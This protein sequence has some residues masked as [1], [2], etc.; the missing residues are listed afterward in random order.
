M[1]NKADLNQDGR[2][3]FNE[4]VIMRKKQRLSGGGSKGGS[5]GRHGSRHATPKRS[6]KEHGGHTSSGHTPKGGASH[7]GASHASKRH[8]AAGKREKGSKH[9]K[10]K[11]SASSASSSG[12]GGGI[13]GEAEIG[14]W[15][16]AHDRVLQAQEVEAIEERRQYVEAMASKHSMTDALADLSDDDVIMLESELLVDLTTDF[17]GNVQSL[18]MDSCISVLNL[19]GLRIG[20]MF[21]A[22]EVAAVVGGAIDGASAAGGSG[23]A[24]TGE[25]LLAALQRARHEPDLARHGVF[26]GSPIR[27]R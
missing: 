20:K 9:G 14:S 16:V 27:A 6:S 21:D 10:A 25:Q 22:A 3:D 11:L 17:R 8:A 26:T 19:L 4:F 12:G 7:A 15:V 24:C 18:S 1:F 13:Q 5:A 2:V 23:H